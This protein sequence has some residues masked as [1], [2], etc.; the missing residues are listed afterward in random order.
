MALVAGFFAPAPAAAIPAFAR[1]YG[2]SCQTCHSVFPKLN[3]FGE[4]FRLNGLR[5]PKETE[6][7]LRE[8]PVSL[9]A[10]AYRRLWPKAVWPGSIPGNLPLAVNVQFADVTSSTT[11]GH[12]VK[13]D[14]QFPQEANLFAGGTLGD[15]ISYFSELTFED[16]PDGSVDAQIEHASIAFDSPIGPLNL[17]HIRLGKLAPILDDGFHEMWL[18]TDAAI[19]PLFAYNPI[20]LRGGAGLAEDIS[21][22]PIDLPAM[23]RGI[24]AYGIIR[25]RLLYVAGI[26]NGIASTSEGRFDANN[27]KDYYARVDYKFGGMGLDGFTGSE[28]VIPEHNWRD[29]SVR[30]GTFVYRGNASGTGFPFTLDDGASVSLEDRR[31]VRTGVFASVFARDLNVFGVYMR[32]SDTIDRFDSAGALAGTIEPHFDAWFI[33]ADYVFYPWPWL[34][35]AFRYQTLAPGDPNVPELRT[36]VANVS[37]LIR[38]NVKGLLEYRRDLRDGRNYSMTVAVRFAF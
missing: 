15:R 38:A 20:G 13:N 5:M 29:N 21:P 25:H 37:A 11:A 17:L 8:K 23:V 4:A 33:E 3:A 26:A 30:V 12:A 31:F 24:E 27:A 16:S 6:A 1:K 32:G 35:G 28:A 34:F 10:P 36:A 22:T 19:D 2:T 18:M 14:F 7:M 9:G